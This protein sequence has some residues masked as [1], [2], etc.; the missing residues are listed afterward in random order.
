MILVCV[1]N[2]LPITRLGH[3]SIMVISVPGFGNGVISHKVKWDDS[4]MADRTLKV[5]GMKPAGVDT[6]LH[7]SVS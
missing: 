7:G 6:T 4:G 3:T 2:F 5:S 1:T